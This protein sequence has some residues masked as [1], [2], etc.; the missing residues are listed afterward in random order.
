MVEK[1][2][3][4]IFPIII[5]PYNGVARIMSNTIPF[6]MCITT[7][8]IKLKFL[9]LPL[10]QILLKDVISFEPIGTEMV[11]VQLITRGIVLTYK[12]GKNESQDVI[13]GYTQ[14]RRTRILDALKKAIPEKELKSF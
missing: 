3:D 10:G 4:N 7:E 1:I 2:I 13:T 11:G 6:S 5:K 8:K 9:G 12:N 14:K